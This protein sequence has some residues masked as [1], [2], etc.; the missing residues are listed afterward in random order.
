[1][2][3]DLESNN[4]LFLH[5]ISVLFADY[6]KTAETDMLR[7]SQRMANR[8]SPQESIAAILREVSNFSSILTMF[9]PQPDIDP[10]SGQILSDEIQWI[11]WSD[12]N[13]AAKIVQKAIYDL[14]IPI[15]YSSVAY[16][17]TPTGY[18]NGGLDLRIPE[19][20]Y[21]KT[22]MK[23]LEEC[24]YLLSHVEILGSLHGDHL[25]LAPA[26]MDTIR[27]ATART[28]PNLREHL[29]GLHHE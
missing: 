18:N 14:L 5:V 6:L 13:N 27:M 1:M 26:L 3:N 23:I 20:K 9:K 19:D 17:T 25:E 16:G 10:V 12:G 11:H 15:L 2:S 4:R 7:L 21:K 29:E 8:I 28:L 24:E 22:T